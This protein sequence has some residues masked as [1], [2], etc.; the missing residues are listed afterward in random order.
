[1]RKK[2]LRKAT[3][4]TS[5]AL[6]AALLLGFVVPRTSA[7]DRAADA[8]REGRPPNIVFIMADDLGYGDLGSYGQEKIRTPHLDRMAREGTRFTQFYAGSTVCAPS[9]S[10]LMTGQHTG[11]TPIGGN[12]EVKPIGQAPLPDSAVTLA[13][14]LKDAGYATGAF[15]KWGLG[16]PDSEGAPWRQGF[17]VFFGYLGQ[18]RAH[19]YYPEFLFRNDVRV[20]LEGNEVAADAP[21]P[22]AGHPVQRSVYSHDVIA[23]SALAFVG[24][25]RDRPFFLY[26]P[27]TIP[28]AELLAPDDA[29][30]MY[31]DSTGQSVFEEEPFEGGH[32]TAQPRPR[33]T[34]AAMIT[35]LDRDV[36]RLL[37]TLEAQGL[38][39]NTLV[40]FTSDNGPHSAGGNDPDFFDSNGPLRGIKRDLY[41]GGIRVPMI[42]W[43]PGRV[44]AGRT[45]EQVW[46]MWDVLPTAAAWADV[47]VPPGVDGLSMAEAVTGGVQPHEHAFLYW[48][49]YEGG[50][51]QA[52]RMGRW[53]AVRQPM[54]TGQI[55]LYDLDADV[56]E[57]TDVA[58]EHPEVVAEI[59]RI[60]EQA[61]TPSPLW[62]A[63]R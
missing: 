29:L 49:F 44:P 8:N 7:Q 14:V 39:E 61:H 19:F 40:F 12:R 51:A 58:A 5:A 23:D 21:S 47:A 32:Y 43:G 2:Q 38:A 20:P 3:P 28:H 33:A 15:G 54:L 25:N 41:E 36:G 30:A 17:D 13:E 34:L 62:Q 4:Y 18:R 50:S 27:F 22:G 42:A 9:R 16:G 35:R 45:S 59:E 26:L 10:V 37:D 52:V 6:L 56:G 55:E 31:L 24:Q 57:T 46:A 1:M 53:K 60:M 63:P 11:R 48:E